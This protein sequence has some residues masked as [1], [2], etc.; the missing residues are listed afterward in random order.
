MSTSVFIGNFM[1]N[2]KQYPSVLFAHCRGDV[3]LPKV[4]ITDSSI[5]IIFYVNLYKNSGFPCHAYGHFLHQ[6]G[7]NWQD[8]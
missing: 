3:S 5:N 7:T 1:K 4:K 8:R 2:A 6:V